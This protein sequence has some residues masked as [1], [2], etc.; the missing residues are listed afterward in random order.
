MARQLCPS[1]SY[2][3][4]CIFTLAWHPRAPNPNSDVVASADHL[5]YFA[6]LGRIAG[7][8]LYHQVGPAFL[9]TY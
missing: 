5:S 8:A 4:C 1:I 9:R 2:K 7:L 3:G 6:L